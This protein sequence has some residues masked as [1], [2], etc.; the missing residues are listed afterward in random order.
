MASP[1]SLVYSGMG[2]EQIWDPGWASSS[3]GSGAVIQIGGY[4]VGVGPAGSAPAPGAPR[5][6]Q[7]ILPWVLL[8]VVVLFALRK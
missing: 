7:D 2:G 6:W 4:R 5:Q 1:K 3:G 8:G